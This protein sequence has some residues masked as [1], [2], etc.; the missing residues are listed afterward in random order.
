MILNFADWLREYLREYPGLTCNWVADGAR[1]GAVEIPAQYEKAEDLRVEWNRGNIRI[2]QLRSDEAC[3]CEEDPKAVRA[4]L[5]RLIEPDRLGRQ[6][7]ETVERLDADLAQQPR[8]PDLI[9]RLADALAELAHWDKARSVSHLSRAERLYRDALVQ[10]ANDPVLL[11]NLGALLFDQGK[12]EE[13]QALFQK[14]HALRPSDRV[15]AYNL[16]GSLVELGRQKKGFAL[17]RES[18]KLS[19]D[20]QTRESRFDPQGY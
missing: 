19:S 2:L 5:D 4:I 1:K 12:T 11:N 3:E 15:I 13:A 10:K 18:Y 7:C 20:G 17:V 14:A 8:N 6:A 16:G 9:R